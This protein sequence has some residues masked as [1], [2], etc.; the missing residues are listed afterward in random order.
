MYCFTFTILIDFHSITVATLE[1]VD[2]FN[3]RRLLEPIGN[4]PPAEAEARYYAQ[5][6]VFDIAA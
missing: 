3:N 2:W 5:I 1:W 6:D 4:I